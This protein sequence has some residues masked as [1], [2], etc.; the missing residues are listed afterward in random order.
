M[1]SRRHAEFFVQRIVRGHVIRILPPFGK[2][3]T[4]RDSA[5]FTH[6]TSFARL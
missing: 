5:F 4:D 6:V 3:F 1:C 2:S